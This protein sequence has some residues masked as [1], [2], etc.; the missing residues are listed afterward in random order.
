MTKLNKKSQATAMTWFVAFII[1]FFIMIIFIMVVT[2]ARVSKRIGNEEVVKVDVE[3][4][5]ENVAENDLSATENFIGF[6]SSPV[7]YNGE[8]LKI[9]NLISGDGDQIE[10]YREEA[11][12][13]M[14][15]NFPRGDEGLFKKTWIRVYNI[16]ENINH[17]YSKSSYRLPWDIRPGSSYGSLTWVNCRPSEKNTISVTI[18]IENN[19]KI[20]LCAKYNEDDKKNE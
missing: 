7:E 18:Y 12:N 15:Q 11:I 14:D 1:I 6:L 13:F 9:L 17:Y 5:E 19:K 3:G 20:V 10:R 16:D 2:V 4:V 8:Q